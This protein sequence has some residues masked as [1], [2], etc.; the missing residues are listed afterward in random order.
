M[1]LTK[2]DSFEVTMGVAGNNK[3]LKNALKTTET[4][5]RQERLA[6]RTCNL[7]ILDVTE[8]LDFDIIDKYTRRRL[9]R[10]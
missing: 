3:H 4:C 2:P 5:T 8:R 6:V 10:V 9:Y 7:E 1:I